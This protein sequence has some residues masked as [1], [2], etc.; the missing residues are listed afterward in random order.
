MKGSAK[1]WW[2]DRPIP[3]GGVYPVHVRVLP[4]VLLCSTLG[5]LGMKYPINTHEQKKGLFFGAHFPFSGVRWALGTSNYL[6]KCGLVTSRWLQISTW[7]LQGLCSLSS[8]WPTKNRPGGLKF[9]TLFIYVY[10][11]LECSN[12]ITPGNHSPDPQKT[13]VL[14]LGIPESCGAVPGDASRVC[15]RGML[16]FSEKIQKTTASNSKP[17]KKHIAIEANRSS[18][19]TV[20]FLV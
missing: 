3:G 5:F 7:I 10:Q 13:T 14:C 16:G 8:F 6:R 2:K 19:A 17:K 18:Q 9:D 12:I 11:G 15:S 1:E 20:S 4:W